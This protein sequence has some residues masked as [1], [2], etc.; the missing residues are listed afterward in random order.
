MSRSRKAPYFTDQ[1][2]SKN[3]RSVWSKR[4]ANRAVRA[5]K[6]APANGKAYRKFSSSWDI[7]DWS[8][9]S[10]DPKARRK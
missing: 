6:A 3:G 1:Q 9:Y 7:R 2:R 4:R 5:S 8:F 10:T